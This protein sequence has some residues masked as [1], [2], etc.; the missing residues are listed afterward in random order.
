MESTHTKWH[1]NALGH[2]LDML[3]FGKTGIPLLLFPTS[4]GTYTQNRDSGL[5][6]SA[7]W[8]ISEGL[9]H[10]YCID[11]FDSNTWYNK[12][13]A[14]VQR[15]QNYQRYET[16][17]ATEL[18][19][20]LLSENNQ[21]RMAVAGCSF[22]AWHAVNI[23]FRHPSMISYLFSMSGMFDI[24]P[25]LDGYYDDTAYFNNPVD[26]VPGLNDPDLWRMG[27]ALGTGEFD[28]CLDANRRFSDLLNAKHVDHW[29]DIQPGASHDWPLWR[30]IF[31]H[32]LSLMNFS[33]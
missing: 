16:M 27:I 15:I 14:P 29:L 13:V 6:D 3:E 2:E 7:A 17:L 1:S 10:I 31:P 26:Y 22:G 18:L 5:I 28:I 33:G 12:S 25:Q 21:K 19:P 24:R 32:Y 30:Q 23:A 11:T 8:F 9:V 20:R 4:M